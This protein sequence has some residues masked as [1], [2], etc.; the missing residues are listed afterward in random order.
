MTTETP[1]PTV[2][3][4][5]DCARSDAAVDHASGE[6]IRLLVAG[7]I[8]WHALVGMAREQR[9]SPLVWASLCRVAP[10][11]VP[12]SSAA[13][14]EAEVKSNTL[15]NLYLTRRLIRLVNLFESNGIQALAYKGPILAAQ[16][17]GQP[18]LR[19]FS[20]LD[21][22]VRV[23]HVSAARGLLLRDGFRQTWP[24]ATLSRD[25]EARHR[26]TKYNFAF[27]QAADRVDLELR[28]GLTPNYLRVPPDPAELWEG[29]EE[30]TL[31]GKRL[32]VFSPARLLLILCVHGGNHCWLRLNWVCDVAELVRRNAGL[33]WQ[34]ATNDARRWGCARILRL[35]LMLA[36][37]L[38]GLELPAEMMDAIAR[39]ETAQR[40]ARQSIRRLTQY[41]GSSLKPF[42]EPLFHLGMRE[43]WTDR[44]RY[45]RAMATP[46][47]KDWSYLP[48]PA[49]LSGLYYVIRPVRLLI[50]HGLNLRRDGNQ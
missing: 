5:L 42:E 33:D 18:S 25:Q 10:E 14:F 26:R 8:D 34:A 36:H 21:L 50:D 6:H 46:T 12:A 32:L 9:V 39:D 29:L 22:L 31:A 24:A 11:A 1:S 45:C 13:E 48:L 7:Q 49:S 40:L 43:Q 17:Y 28:W 4:L 27:T 3:L 35:G 15:R 19:Q 44:A 38:L 37:E 47:V 23:E 2:E 41:P 30:I 20:D 16:A